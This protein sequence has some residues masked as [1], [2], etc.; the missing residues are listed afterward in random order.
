MDVRPHLN[1]PRREGLASAQPS[2][3]RNVAHNTSILHCE[4]DAMVNIFRGQASS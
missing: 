2:R 1:P 3:K 4:A